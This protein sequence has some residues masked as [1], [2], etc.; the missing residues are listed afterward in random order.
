MKHQTQHTVLVTGASQGIG[1]S[2]ARHFA[3][4]GYRVV[5]SARNREKL[6]ALAHEIGGS[7]Y[8][9]NV[10]DPTQIQETLK[11]I[12]TEVSPI[13]ILVIAGIAVSASLFNQ[14]GEIWLCEFVGELSFM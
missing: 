10:S 14:R 9:M 4:P 13:D 3:K 5:L 11:A 6:A 8:P 2:I 1:A 7:V 12:E